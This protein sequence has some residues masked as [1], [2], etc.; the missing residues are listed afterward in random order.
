MINLE[1]LK[2]AMNLH[3]VQRFQTHRLQQPKSVAEHSFRVFFIYAYLGGKELIAAAGHDLEEAET[4]DIPSPA[5]KKMSGL[6]K[7]EAMR[8]QFEDAKEARL[9]KLA[10]KLDLVLDLREQLE[11]TG[12]LPRKLRT[13]YEDELELVM[14]I[15]KELGKVKEVKQLLKDLQK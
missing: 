15:A 11:D 6:D 12:T 2:L 5:K 1:Q 3:N 7:F 13:I 8:P 10:D 4:G 9:G 14:D